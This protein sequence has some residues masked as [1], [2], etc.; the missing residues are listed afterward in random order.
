MPKFKEIYTQTI[1][2]Q[3]IK[4]LH[5][6]THTAWT[7][8]HGLMFGILLE[9][10]QCGIQCWTLLTGELGLKII[11]DAM[12]QYGLNSDDNWEIIPK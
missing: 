6:R 1:P 11:G 5:Q 9:N 7:F 8:E 3:E 2:Y 10:R 12:R 4:L